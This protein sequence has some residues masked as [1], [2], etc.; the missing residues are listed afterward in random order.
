[1]KD[2][3]VAWQTARKAAAR[4][5]ALAAQLV[6]EPPQAPWR[7]GP[8]DNQAPGTST[9][10][11]THMEPAGSVSSEDEEEDRADVDDALEAAEAAAEAAFA[12]EDTT[13]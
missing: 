7:Q 2:K 8:T 6:L 1:M 5:R 4:K 3:A 9:A 11:P 13:P 12:D 10:A